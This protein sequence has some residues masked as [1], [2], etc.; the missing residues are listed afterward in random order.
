MIIYKLNCKRCNN[1][2]TPRVENPKACPYCK[3]PYWN[4]ER[5]EKVIHKPNPTY[6]TKVE[7]KAMNWLIKET[8]FSMEEVM[9]KPSS[10]PDFILPDGS[11]Y[12]IKEIRSI[13]IAIPKKQWEHLCKYPNCKILCFG[14]S[15][16]PVAIIPIANLEYNLGKSQIVTCFSKFYK[17]IRIRFSEK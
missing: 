8:G 9:H 4:K 7:T 16:E 6:L 17:F 1:E 12:E 14:G 10:S 5:Q 13:T 15:N 3:S 11:A 2:W